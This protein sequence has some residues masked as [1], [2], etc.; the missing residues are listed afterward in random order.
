MKAMRYTLEQLNAMAPSAFVAALSGIFE[1]SP[2]VAELAAAERPFAS[3][4]EKPTIVVSG[5]RRSCEI[6]DSSELRSRSDSM[7]T[8]A[9]RAIST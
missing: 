1:H 4:D 2:W 8:S 3:I 5:V 7:L 6:A 9:S